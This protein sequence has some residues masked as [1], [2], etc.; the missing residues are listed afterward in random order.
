M[1]I[2]PAL[3]R[4]PVPRGLERVPERALAEFWTGLDL[5]FLQYLCGNRAVLSVPGEEGEF[6][7]VGEEA[8]GGGGDARGGVQEDDAGTP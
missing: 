7:G 3:E 6:G 2:L 1:R 4:E 8:G 5:H